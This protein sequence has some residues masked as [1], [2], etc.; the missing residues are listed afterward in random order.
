MIHLI[1]ALILILTFVL[2]CAVLCW[3][4]DNWIS[5][6]KKVSLYKLCRFEACNLL[7]PVD[8]DI[9]K[10]PTDKNQT[11]AGHMWL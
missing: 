10:F 7:K 1:L 5:L 8:M 9:K 11:K 3:H 4:W 2:S 6:I